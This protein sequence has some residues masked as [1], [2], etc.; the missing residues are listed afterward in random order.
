[1][2]KY[3]SQLDFKEED[4]VFLLIDNKINKE[5]SYKVIKMEYEEGGSFYDGFELKIF[6]Y[7]EDEKLNIIEKFQ[8]AF[9]SD[10][11]RIKS[12]NAYNIKNIFE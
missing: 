3:F 7:L 6:A 1:M 2:N 8:V 11:N 9:F 12:I 5:K 4:S 10:F